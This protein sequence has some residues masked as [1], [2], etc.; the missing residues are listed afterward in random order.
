[1]QSSMAAARPGPRASCRRGPVPAC[2]S[3]CRPSPAPVDKQHR[4]GPCRRR[5]RRGLPCRR[6]TNALEIAGADIYLGG[7]EGMGH[8][9]TRMVEGVYGRLSIDDLAAR[10][11]RA[12]GLYCN[13]PAPRKR[14]SARRAKKTAQSTHVQQHRAESPYSADPLD[15]SPPKKTPCLP[16]TQCPE[17][18]SN[19]RH[20]DFQSPALPTELS[21]RDARFAPREGGH[22]TA[23][24]RG[25]NGE[26]RARRVRSA[27]HGPVVSRPTAWSRR[28]TAVV[29]STRALKMA[30][31]ALSRSDSASIRSDV[32]ARPTRNRSVV[33]R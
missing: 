14:G 5:H 24:Y 10:L 32:V 6:E 7:R 9:D 16:Q 18:E 23:R 12:I 17:T 15:T 8:A 27:P 29:R 1:M 4:S 21:G 28:I 26:E 13:T 31:R 11:P 19:R 22:D 20:G 30:R 3:R 25:V 33:T 2:R